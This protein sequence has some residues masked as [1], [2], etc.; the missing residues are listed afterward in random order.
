DIRRGNLHEHLLYKAVMELS[1]DRVEFLSRLFARPKPAGIT[2]ATPLQQIFAAFQR[3]PRSETL[4]AQNP[5][6]I[7]KWLTEHHRFPLPPADVQAIDYIYREA[8]AA[9]GPDLTYQRTD[10]STFTGPSYAMLMLRTDPAGQNRSY[11]ATEDGFQFLK[12]LETR[13]LV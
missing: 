12:D 5:D 13:N 11:L 4:Y 10:A 1:A 8:F 2:S 6:A 7:L 3:T 9:Y